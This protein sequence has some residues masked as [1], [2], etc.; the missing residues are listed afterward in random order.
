MHI[1]KVVVES[2]SK[3]CVEAL[4]RTPVDVHWEIESLLH[5]Q[6]AKELSVSFAGHSTVSTWV[7]YL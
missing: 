7:S 2:D 3:Q 4:L 6:S 1:Q 5:L